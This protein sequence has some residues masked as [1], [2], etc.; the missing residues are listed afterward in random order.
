MSKQLEDTVIEEILNDPKEQSTM[1]VTRGKPG[2]HIW[3]KPIWTKRSEEERKYLREWEARL[4]TAED[5][6]R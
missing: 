6:V 3:K 2:D 5:A 1:R 4:R